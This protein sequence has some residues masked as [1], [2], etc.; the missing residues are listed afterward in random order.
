[1][2]KATKRSSDAESGPRKKAKVA[3]P[4]SALLDDISAT[5]PTES[6]RALLHEHIFPLVDQL[7]ADESSAIVAAFKAES[8]AATKDA[9]P[10]TPKTSK[11]AKSPKAKDGNQLKTKHAEHEKK[12]KEYMKALKKSINQRWKDYEGHSHHMSMIAVEVLTW[13]EELFPV[14][15]EQKTQLAEVHK[16]L[17]TALDFV[18]KMEDATA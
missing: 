15:M 14:A 8:A 16:S 10:A 11:A 3:K 7:P 4:S 12:L 17:L 5:L 1:M 13:L 2:P 18:D 6:L 9:G